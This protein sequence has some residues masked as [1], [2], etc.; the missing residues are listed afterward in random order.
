[1]KQ[2]LNEYIS[3][4][5]TGC[6]LCHSVK[7]TKLECIK[8]GFPSAVIQDNEDL[9]FYKM[10]CP[11]FYYEGVLNHDVWGKIEKAY[12]G[13]SSNPVTRFNASSG[14]ALTE[15]CEYLLEK[16]AVDGIIHTTFDID[17]PTQT[18]TVV[19]ST[20]EEVRSRSGSRYSISVP[21]ENILYIVEKGKKYAFVGKPCD[22]MA[23]R[24]YFEINQQLK[25]Q[26]KYLLSFFCAGEPSVDAQNNLLKNMGC[27]HGECSQLRYRGNGWPGYTTIVK[28]DG[29]EAKLEY[30][31]AWGNYL[32]RDLRNVCRF[33]LD[34]T[35]DAADIVC[36]DFWHLNDS[37]EPDFSEHEGRN[38]IISRNSKGSEVLDSVVKD[39]R[40]IQEC[41]FTNKIF[42][43]FHKYQPAQYKRKGSMKAV[44]AAL[45]LFGRSVPNYNRDCL[46]YYSVHLQFKTR[47]HYFYGTIKRIIKGKL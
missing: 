21:L 41:D 8:G 47:I 6:G 31:V 36:A 15:I 33:C 38:I 32:G 24:R 40:I 23:L 26:I 17:D 22:V 29:T 11:V 4:F 46:K 27:E 45:R 39:G 37:G 42:S 19:S 12:V 34:G 7:K 20:V 3:T 9:G 18:I 30:K 16:K 13:Y 43:D 2:K 28:K 10:V 5:C 44:I 14:G 25:K 1:M 35:G